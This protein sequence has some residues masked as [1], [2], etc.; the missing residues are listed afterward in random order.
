MKC[1]DAERLISY[2]YRLI[3]EPAASEVCKHLEECAPCREIVEQH[4]RLDAVLSEW[5][6]PEP[7]PE[8]DVRVRE[9]VG[10]LEAQREGWGFW[11]WQWARGLALAALG[12]MIVAGVAWFGHNHRGDPRSSQVATRQPQQTTGARISGRTS[13]LRTPLEPTQAQVIPAHQVPDLKATDATSS[14]DRD[15]LAMED[16]DLAANFDLLS[17]IPKGERRVAN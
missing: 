12:V 11:G 6:S 14:D 3:D 15:A 2:A 13:N 10:A 4:G 9:A 1:L 7:S 8:F 17:E 5:Q 16:Y